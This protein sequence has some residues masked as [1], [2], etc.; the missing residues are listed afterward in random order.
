MSSFAS[1]LSGI[2]AASWLVTVSAGNV[3]NLNSDGYRAKRVTFGANPD[4][5]VQVQ[6]PTES[7]AEPS[8]GGSNV[9]LAEEM[10]NLMVGKTYFA[11]NAAA[12]RTEGQVTGMALDLKA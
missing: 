5:T 10:I 7:Q 6:A 4:G 9:D 8:P 1:S 3:A 2:N 11:A 12:L